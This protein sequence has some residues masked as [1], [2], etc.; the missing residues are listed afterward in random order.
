MFPSKPAAR[1][2]SL[3]AEFGPSSSSAVREQ[4]WLVLFPADLVDQTDSRPSGVLSLPPW[5]WTGSKTQH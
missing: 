4:I 2:M 1:L 3:N 5:L